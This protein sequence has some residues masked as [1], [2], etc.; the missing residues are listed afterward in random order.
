MMN[1]YG[2]GRRWS[3]LFYRVLPVLSPSPTEINYKAQT[4]YGIVL[5]NL[6]RCISVI[7]SKVGLQLVFRK[8]PTSLPTW[9]P[10][11]LTKNFHD[12]SQSVQTNLHIVTRIL[13]RLRSASSSVF[14]KWYRHVYSLGKGLEARRNP[15]DY[16]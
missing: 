16:I 9:R 5:K 8:V 15:L 14:I 7:R 11:I 4:R 6:H 12:F 3:C 2:L 1:V 10:T 13:S